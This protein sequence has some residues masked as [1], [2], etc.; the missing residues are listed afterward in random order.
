MLSIKGHRTRIMDNGKHGCL[1]EEQAQ[2][3][4]GISQRYD[5]SEGIGKWVAGTS[6]SCS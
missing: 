3:K 2:D 4:S 1:A 6:L 5:H